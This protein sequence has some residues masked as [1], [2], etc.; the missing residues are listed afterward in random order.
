MIRT[1]IGAV[2]Y[3]DLRDFSVGPAILD[4][5]AGQRWPDAVA[6]ENLSYNPISVVHRLDEAKPPFSRLVL[7][8]AVERG[9]TPGSLVAYRWDGGLPDRE[10]IQDRVAEAVTG[11]I[12]LENLAIVVAA[13]G[14]APPQICIVE[15]E[16]CME[17]M[18]SDLSEAVAAAASDAEQ[19]VREIALAPGEGSPA[20][21][22]PLGGPATTNGHPRTP[23]HS[24]P[25]DGRS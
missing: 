18:G 22:A 19:I 11:V 10:A 2:G 3:S 20:P 4:R 23:L 21:E 12:S 7:I 15:I 14:A 9:R 16:P 13:L 6:L 24:H 17:G 1:L 8:G 5:L 25:Y